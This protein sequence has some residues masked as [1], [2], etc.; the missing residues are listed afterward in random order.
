MLRF[1]VKERTA[2]GRWEEVKITEFAGR[3]VKDALLALSGREAV[4]ELVYNGITY[5]LCSTPLWMERMQAKGKAMLIADMV[6]TLQDNLVE[7]LHEKIPHADAVARIFPGATLES[8]TATK[9]KS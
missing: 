4:A 5:Y 2:S 7:L 3:S 8:H 9:G 1:S 6:K